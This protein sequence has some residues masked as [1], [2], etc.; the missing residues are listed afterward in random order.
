MMRAN[1]SKKRKQLIKKIFKAGFVSLVLLIF[2]LI[3]TTLNSTR[4]FCCLPSSVSFVA[5]GCK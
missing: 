3:L 5:I 2:Y 4:L 1:I